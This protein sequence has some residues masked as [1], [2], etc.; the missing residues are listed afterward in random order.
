MHKGALTYFKLH[1]PVSANTNVK[2]ILQSE[3]NILLSQ[4]FGGKARKTKPIN[5]DTSTLSCIYSWNP[6]YLKAC[7]QP[8]SLILWILQIFRSKMS[9]MALYYLNSSCQGNMVQ[10]AVGETT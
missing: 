3:S 6:R 7:R 10:K 4:A 2:P 9:N 1:L 5:K 8:G